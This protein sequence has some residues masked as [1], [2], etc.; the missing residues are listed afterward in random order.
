MADRLA[1]MHT[2][3]HILSAIMRIYYAAPRNLELHLNEKKTKCDY[4]PAVPIDEAA[5][6][7]IESMVNDEIRKDHA[8]SDFTISREDAEKRGF[9]LWKVPPDTDEIRIVKI[10]ELDAQ[11]CSGRHVGRTAEIGVFRIISH[12]I[13]DSGRLRIRFKV[14]DA[15]EERKKA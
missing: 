10:G 6:Q 4:E 5:I 12:D 14:V 15:G 1:R 8:V 11:P 13:R 9:D 3:E 7:R 2:A